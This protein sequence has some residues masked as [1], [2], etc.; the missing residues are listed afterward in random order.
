M[1]FHNG[2]YE[3]V[4]QRIMQRIYEDATKPNNRIVK[5]YCKT[6]IDNFTGYITG[7]PITYNT[8][9]AFFECLKENDVEAQDSEW[10]KKALINGSAPMLCYMNEYSDKRFK[11]LDPWQVIP[12]Y[13]ADLD[14]EL[15]YCIYY[16]AG[17]DWD[18]DE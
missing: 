8:D 4:G 2:Y 13:A 7:K 6:I 11:V 17:V 12:V 14:E 15:L 10:L 1:K 16:H 5:N 3:G 18:T 9:D